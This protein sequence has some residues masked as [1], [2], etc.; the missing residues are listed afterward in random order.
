MV[1]GGRMGGAGQ[2][3]AIDQFG[4]KRQMAMRVGATHFINSSETDPVKAVRELT[5]GGGVDHAF[6]AVGNAKI[7]RHAIEALA[8]PRNANIVCMLPPDPPSQ[9]PR[10][11]IQ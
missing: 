9:L 2:I 1:Q 8:V 4:Q 10:S 7:C 3:I 5:G 6:E 11:A